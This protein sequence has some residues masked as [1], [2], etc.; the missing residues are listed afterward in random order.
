MPQLLHGASEKLGFH[1]G[2]HRD[3]DP[4]SEQRRKLFGAL[5]NIVNTTAELRNAGFGTGHGGTQRPQLDVATARLVVSAAV[6][7]ATFYIE[8]H[9]VEARDD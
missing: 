4:G 5:T 6:A 1:P 7:V 2:G 9:S 3:N 8:A